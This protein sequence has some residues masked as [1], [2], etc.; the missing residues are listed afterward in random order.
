[1]VNDPEIRRYNRQ[2]LHHDWVTDVIAF[3]MGER[4]NL[5]EVL[6]SFDTARRQAKAEGHTRFKELMILATHGLLHLVG[7]TDTRK[8]DRD[9]MWR[10]TKE[11]LQEG[12][13]DD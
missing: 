12:G 11:L 13:I 8:A 10:L 2:F 1:M 7:Y 6:V 4:D 5:G 9:R 3:P